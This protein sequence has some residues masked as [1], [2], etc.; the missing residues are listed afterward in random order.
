MTELEQ[1]RID[2]LKQTRRMYA[3]NSTPAVH[4]RYKN[5]YASIYGME[6][7]DEKKENTFGV[8]MIIAI[9]LFCLFVLAN[10]KEMEEAKIVSNLIQQEF[11]GFIDLPIGD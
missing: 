1:R 10:Q 2:L 4:P 9:L 8:R 11:D 5:A 3:D 6:E 7:R